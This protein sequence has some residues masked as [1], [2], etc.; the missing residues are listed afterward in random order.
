[1]LLLVKVINFYI[2]WLNWCVP[3]PRLT[4]VNALTIENVAFGERN[5]FLYKL[6]CS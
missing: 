6:V 4:V 5:Y 3:D 1:M 2:N